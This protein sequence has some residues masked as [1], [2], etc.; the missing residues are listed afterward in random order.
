M[1]ATMTTQQHNKQTHTTQHKSTPNN[2]N[3]KIQF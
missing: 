3:T 1:P 2:R